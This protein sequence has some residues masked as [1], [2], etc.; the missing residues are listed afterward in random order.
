ML[1]TECEHAGVAA[2]L[3][4]AIALEEVSEGMVPV[5]RCLLEAIETPAEVSHHLHPSL[6]GMCIPLRP[7]GKVHVEVGLSERCIQERSGDIKLAEGPVVL[8]SK[9]ED[10]AEGGKLGHWSKCI[11]IV[12]AI[13]LSEALHTHSGLVLDVLTILISLH[14]EHPPTVE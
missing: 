1:I 3:L 9:S 6:R 12:N 2:C 10:A 7:L 11:C 14:F 4:E 8:G 5:A 13:S